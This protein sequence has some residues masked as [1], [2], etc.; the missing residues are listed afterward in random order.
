MV[1]WKTP[2]PQRYTNNRQGEGKRGDSAEVWKPSIT[3]GLKLTSQQDMCIRMQ[4]W[5]GYGQQMPSGAV[6]RAPR[7]HER[8]YAMWESLPRLGIYRRIENKLN[9]DCRSGS[10]EPLCGTNWNYG[11]EKWQTTD[12]SHNGCQCTWLWCGLGKSP[13]PAVRLPWIWCLLL[14]Q[15][16]LWAPVGSKTH[17]DSSTCTALTGFSPLTTSLYSCRSAR[18]SPLGFLVLLIYTSLQATFTVRTLQLYFQAH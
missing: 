9:D 15:V 14:Q 3:E 4:I 13:T 2:K 18:L 16:G 11:F 10:K 7:A 12:I 5:A 6:K 1:D 8:T 17:R